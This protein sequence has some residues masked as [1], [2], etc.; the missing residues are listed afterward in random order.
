MQ[1][2]LLKF[3]VALVITGASALATSALAQQTVVVG[4]GNPAWMY[5]QFRRPSISV[6]KSF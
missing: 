2:L 5:P 6:G 4:T 3:R 1:Q